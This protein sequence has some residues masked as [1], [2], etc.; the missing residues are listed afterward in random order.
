MSDKKETPATELSDEAVE[1]VAGGDKL[2]NFEIQDLKSGFNQAESTASSFNQAQ[3]LGFNQAET[4]ASS[5][6]KK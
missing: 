1:G 2:G 6:K 3:T 4:L 5:I